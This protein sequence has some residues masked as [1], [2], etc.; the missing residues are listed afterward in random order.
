MARKARTT[1]GTRDLR[2]IE[3]G[4]GSFG[5]HRVVTVTT[6]TYRY[7]LG[8][9]ENSTQVSVQRTD[10]N[11]GPGLSYI[12]SLLFRRNAGTSKSD[13]S[14][15]AIIASRMLSMAIVSGATLDA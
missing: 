12:V 14:K 9:Q 1:L 8:W 4:T 3:A 11:L 7:S 2:D 10:A 15:L 6:P 13:C 5:N